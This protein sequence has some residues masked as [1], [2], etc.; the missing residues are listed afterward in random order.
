MK[1][2]RTNIERR[3]VDVGVV[4]TSRNDGARLRVDR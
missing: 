1:L 3:V 4:S 2:K